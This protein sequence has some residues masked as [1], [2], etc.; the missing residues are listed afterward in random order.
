[1]CNQNN[2]WDANC[3]PNNQNNEWDVNCRPNNQSTRV[4]YKNDLFVI[5]NNAL[6]NTMAYYIGSAVKQ[7]QS[8]VSHRDIYCH[9]Q[10]S[11][12]AKQPNTLCQTLYKYEGYCW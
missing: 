5:L 10:A 11:K 3:R 12:N 2:E 9:K 6:M 4:P 7:H 8:T 1:M